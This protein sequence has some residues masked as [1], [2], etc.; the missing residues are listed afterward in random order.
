MNKTRMD[1]DWMSIRVSEF[2]R[3]TNLEAQ[4]K[5]QEMLFQSLTPGGSEFVNNPKRCVDWIRDQVDSQHR[6][7]MRALHRK[8]AAEAR[9]EGLRKAV[10]LGLQYM[11]NHY[12]VYPGEPDE[13]GELTA[14]KV[15]AKMQKALATPEEA[16]TVK[17]VSNDRS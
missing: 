3:L 8:K 10:G 1:P 9:V 17:G 6:L 14:D 11:G 15:F 7:L 16:L 4:L 5:E 2:E 12:E 13:T